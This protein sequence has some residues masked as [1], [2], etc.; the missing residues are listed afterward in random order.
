MYVTCMSLLAYFAGDLGPRSRLTLPLVHH[1]P[2]RETAN[3]TACE[4]AAVISDLHHI[5][6]VICKMHTLVY[7]SIVY[8]YVIRL[9]QEGLHSVADA[10][11][12]EHEMNGREALASI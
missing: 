11:E 3:A 12:Q 10:F 9:Q 7:T 4:V 5:A 1:Q 6:P 2:A 8:S